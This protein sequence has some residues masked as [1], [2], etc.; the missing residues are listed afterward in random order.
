MPGMPLSRRFY[1][2][3]QLPP[4]PCVYTRYK[5]PIEPRRGVGHASPVSFV[6]S[7][8][9]VCTLAFLLS[10]CGQLAR[11]D[12]TPTPVPLAT[13]PTFMLVC[14]LDTLPCADYIPVLDHINVVFGPGAVH[15]DSVDL[16]LI[17]D[18]RRAEGLG[19]ALD[20][21]LPIF[22]VYTATDDVVYQAVGA[23]DIDALTAAIIEAG[24][25]RE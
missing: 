12:S 17:F 10:G 3:A 9:W 5:H 7:A 19:I 18:Q 4:N 1:F 23:P 11:V 16:D 2:V 13:T 8:F 25:T 20:D 14:H 6:L 21:P 15:Y 22:R 24:G